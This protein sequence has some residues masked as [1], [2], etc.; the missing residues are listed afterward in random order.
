MD[1]MT[2]TEGLAEIKTINARITKR[3]ESALRYFARDV[4]MKDPINTMGGS[5]AFVASERQAVSDLEQRKIAIRSAIQISNQ[6]IPLTL[7]GTTRFVGAWLNWRREV[8]PQAKAFLEKMVSG[9]NDVRQRALRQGFKVTTGTES[10][11]PSEIVVA[12]DETELARDVEQMEQTLGD[13]DGKLSLLNA[14]TTIEL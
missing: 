4:R 12:V 8:A 1:K 14:T 3:T 13:L 9:L 10:G 11:D 7:N 5:T 2:I 6:Q